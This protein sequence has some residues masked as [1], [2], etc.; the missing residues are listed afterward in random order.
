MCRDLTTNNIASLQDNIFANLGALETLY[1]LLTVC[2]G[3]KATNHA[4][5]TDHVYR[6]CRYLYSLPLLTSLSS[7]AFKGLTSLERLYV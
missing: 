1:G 3:Q 4:Y 5:A 7:N 2:P 6:A